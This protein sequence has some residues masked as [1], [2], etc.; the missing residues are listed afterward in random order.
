M[1]RPVK[2]RRIACVPV[3]S[4]FKPAGVP[5]RDLEE[6]VLGLDEVEA[7]RLTDLEKLYQLEAA[8]QQLPQAVQHIQTLQKNIQDQQETL[9][10]QQKA[11]QQLDVKIAQLQSTVQA[12]SVQ[13][14]QLQ[15][16]LF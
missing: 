13:K 2:Q 10:Q 11:L 3:A 4:Y 6:I 9:K 14:Q 8:E 15:I 12:F 5:L 7:M 16:G 1:A